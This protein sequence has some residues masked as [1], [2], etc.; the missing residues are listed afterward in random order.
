MN[1][2]VKRVAKA[3]EGE[4]F[5]PAVGSTP[6]SRLEA[7]AQAAIAVM[8]AEMIRISSL[9]ANSRTIAKAK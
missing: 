1:G 2:M 3:I 6:E 4:I 8:A 7:A 5:K 9:K